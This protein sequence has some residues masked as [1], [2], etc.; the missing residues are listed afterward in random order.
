MKYYTVYKVTNINTKQVYIGVHKTSNLDDGYMGSGHRIKRAIKK[1]GLNNFKKEYIAI[2]DNAEE[3]YQLERELV[4]EEFLANT[5]SYNL[6]CG[7]K[8]DS[9]EFINKNNLNNKINNCYLGGLGQKESREN[10]PEKW[11]IIDEQNSKNMR[12]RHRLG[13]YSHHQ[14]S[15][16]GRKH[17]IET[18]EAMSKSH[19]GKHDREKNSQFG[20][21]WICNIELQQNKKISKHDEIPNGWLLG[22]NRWNK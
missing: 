19:E 8:G 2:F 9:F 10:N 1:Y 4:N 7:G 17:S 14:P 18:K 20:T 11:K 5:N 3:M 13:K 22:R 12:E 21:R 6:T 15:F 16:A